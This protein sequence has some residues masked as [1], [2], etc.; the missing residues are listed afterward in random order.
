MILNPPINDLLTEKTQNDLDSSFHLN[1]SAFKSYGEQKH[2]V[3]FIQIGR[4]LFGYEVSP[5]LAF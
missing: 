3:R 1:F 2:S 5:P 4:E